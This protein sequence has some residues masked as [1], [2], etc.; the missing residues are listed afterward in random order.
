[1][2]QTNKNNRAVCDVL[3]RYAF[4]NERG[5]LPEST[6]SASHIYQDH[7]QWKVDRD[8]FLT[9]GMFEGYAG[10]FAAGFKR[11]N[12]TFADIYEAWESFQAFELIDMLHLL[13]NVIGLQKYFAETLPQDDVQEI[14]RLWRD[15]DHDPAMDP[16]DV[17]EFMSSATTNV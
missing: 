5:Y 1:M 12:L 11:F 4:E 7:L 6:L 14:V 2:C 8:Y 17:Q 16:G 10:D 9:Q 3:M 15:G 13:S